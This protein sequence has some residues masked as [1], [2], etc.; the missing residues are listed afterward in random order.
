M[1]THPRNNT[2]QNGPRVVTVR[3]V[4]S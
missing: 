2:V 1:K 4:A 3:S